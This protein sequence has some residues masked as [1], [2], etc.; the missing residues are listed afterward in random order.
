MKIRRTH[1]LILVGTS[2]LILISLV[3]AFAAANTVPDARLTDHSFVP[4]ANDLKPP[5]CAGLNLVNILTGSGVINGTQDND[6][7]LG[8]V[9]DDKLQGKN[10]D[11]CLVGGDGDDNLTG[12]NGWDV[13]IGGAGN[14]TFKQCEVEWQ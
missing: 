11:D 2:T 1:V 3:S 7:I 6:L 13:C 9:G 5:E 4:D 10:G 8:D 14:D 12:N